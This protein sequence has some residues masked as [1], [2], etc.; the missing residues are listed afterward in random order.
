MLIV[1]KHDMVECLC[2]ELGNCLVMVS[3]LGEPNL[4]IFLLKISCDLN[5][6]SKEKKKKLKNYFWAKEKEHTLFKF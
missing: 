2:N 4:T 3:N 5:V 6:L 1:M